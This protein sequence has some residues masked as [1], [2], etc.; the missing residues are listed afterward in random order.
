MCRSQHNKWEDNKHLMDAPHLPR[1]TRWGRCR[2]TPP[3]CQIYTLFKC[4]IKI[5]QRTRL[6]QLTYLTTPHRLRSDNWGQFLTTECTPASVS[7]QHHLRTRFTSLGQFLEIV[8]SPRSDSF[9]HS[10]RSRC[11]SFSSF[12]SENTRTKSEDLSKIPFET[13]WLS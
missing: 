5:W 1:K 4:L 2:F 11:F 9:A 8:I 13:L 12:D 10:D 6:L 7:S 3:P